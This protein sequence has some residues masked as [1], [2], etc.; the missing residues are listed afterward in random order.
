M[1]TTVMAT[2]VKR[3]LGTLRAIVALKSPPTDLNKEHFLIR[4]PY[5][6]SNYQRRNNNRRNNLV[7]QSNAQ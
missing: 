5:E 3:I 6:I 1:Q 4:H 7:N 2:D